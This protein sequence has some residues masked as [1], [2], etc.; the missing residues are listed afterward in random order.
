[1]TIQL[2]IP[3]T[4]PEHTHPTPKFPNFFNN[5]LSLYHMMY[6][7]DV[8][9]QA[10]RKSIATYNMVQP[11]IPTS[12]LSI[13]NPHPKNFQTWNSHDQNADHGYSSIL[14]STLYSKVV[15]TSE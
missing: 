12:T 4:D 11:S 3:Y 6:S 13:Q 14:Y 1:M 5:G 9:E 10:N 15:R 2:S 8:A 7:K